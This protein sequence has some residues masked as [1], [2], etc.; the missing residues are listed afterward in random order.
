VNSIEVTAGR[1]IHRVWNQEKLGGVQRLAADI[2]QA[3]SLLGFRPKVTLAEGLERM[4]VEDPRFQIDK[5][6]VA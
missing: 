2:G 6:A 4:L 1:A 3:K 5:L